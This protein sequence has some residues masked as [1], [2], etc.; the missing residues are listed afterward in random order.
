[1]ADRRVRISRVYS[2]FVDR[3]AGEDK[4]DG[5]FGLRADVLAFAAALGVKFGRRKS[6]DD[7]TKEPIRLAV[8]ESHNYGPLINILAL[9]KDDDPSILGSEDEMEDKRATILEEY[10]NGGLEFLEEKLRG[11]L[12][13][14]QGVVQLMNG[15]RKSE[16]QGTT[17]SGSEVSVLER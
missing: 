10:A 11:H 15:E 2:E 6:F 1:M 13:E 5:V 7:A 3:L 16:A 8:F 4:A 12:D 17:A 14:L 9:G